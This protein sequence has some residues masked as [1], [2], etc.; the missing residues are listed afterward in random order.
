M[1]EV[2]SQSMLSNA[3]LGALAAVCA[4]VTQGAR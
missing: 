1:A 4:E 3:F 2:D